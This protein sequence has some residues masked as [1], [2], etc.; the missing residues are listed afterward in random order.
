MNEYYDDIPFNCI[1][2]ME[3]NVAL[4]KTRI[5][6]EGIEKLLNIS[7]KMILKKLPKVLKI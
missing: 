2:V 6:K 3:D 4:D 5:F 7:M 1:L